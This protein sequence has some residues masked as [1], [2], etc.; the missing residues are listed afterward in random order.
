MLFPRQLLH[1]LPQGVF[2]AWLMALSFPTPGIWFFMFVG[3]GLLLPAFRYLNLVESFLLG[4]VTGFIY[5]GVLAQWT[6]VY[7]GLLPWLG[8]VSVQAVL[9]ALGSVIFTL[10]WRFGDSFHRS[11]DIPTM[12]PH[13][14]VFVVVTAVAVASAWT[15]RESVAATWPF[16][17]FAWGRVIHSQAETVFGHLVTIFGSSVAGTVLVA[18]TLWIVLVWSSRFETAVSVRYSAIAIGILTAFIPAAI[19]FSS[20]TGDTIRVMAVQGNSNS[21][22]FADIAPGDS[23]RAHY[24][25]MSD[26]WNE[27]VDVVLWPENAA[28]INPLTN[29]SAGAVADQISDEFDAPFVFGTITWVGDES[30]NSVVK[31]EFGAGAT[32]QYDKIHPVPF[33]EYL[34]ERDFFYPLAPDMFDMVPRDYSFGT[35]DTIFEIADTRVGINI[36][37]DIVD[38]EIFRD[39]ISDGAEVIFSPTNNADFGRSHQSIQQLAIAR[40]RAME[41]GRAVVNDSTVGVSAIIAADGSDIVRLEPFAPGVMVAD[42]PVSSVVTPAMAFGRQAESVVLAF[43]LLPLVYW[44]RRD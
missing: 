37:Y 7:L 36:C 41:T 25:A 9:F 38:D 13:K 35:R 15:L 10:A 26:Y 21:A 19:A 32:D 30:F 16:G 8:L 24:Q 6:T 5:Y 17:G 2:G 11:T 20:P 23:I 40:I 43:G 3:L 1:A 22:L 4:S 31:W 34:P 14:P 28:D 29:P 39:M 12:A 27:S 42:V 18:A 44:R 33:A